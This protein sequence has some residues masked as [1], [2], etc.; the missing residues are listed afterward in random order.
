MRIQKGSRIMFH[1][2][3]QVIYKANGVCVIEEIVWQEM[4]AMGKTGMERCECYLL[5]PLHDMAIKIYVPIHNEMLVS[6]VHPIMAPDQMLAL[7]DRASTLTLPWINEL[8]ARTNHFRDLMNKGDR[9][10]L[11]AIIKTIYEKRVEMQN[12]GKKLY[13]ADETVLRKA[14]SLLFEEAAL[15]LEMSENDVAHLFASK[16]DP[17]GEEIAR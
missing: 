11:A 15:I 9:E 1:I 12:I 4:P 10:L 3:D 17:L 7:F 5:R 13:A 14:E 2:G 6:C 16:V 8:R